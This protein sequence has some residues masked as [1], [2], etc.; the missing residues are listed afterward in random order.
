LK[1]EA[2]SLAKK[3]PLMDGD[4][5]E[6][7]KADIAANGL[8]NPVWIWQVKI[9]DGRNRMRACEELGIEPVFAE[10][11]GTEEEAAAFVDSQNLHRRH[12]STEWRR[13]RAKELRAKGMSL[14]GIGRELGVHNSTVAADLKVKQEPAGNPAPEPPPAAIEPPTPQPAPEPKPPPV[15]QPPPPP[16]VTGRD[17]KTY[18]ASKPV[19]AKSAEEPKPPDDAT[20][21]EKWKQLTD[22]LQSV[23]FTF[24][25]FNTDKGKPCPRKFVETMERTGRA[26]L[27]KA[28]ELRKRHSI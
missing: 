9:L 15:Q 14:R 5:Y 3:Y 11:V 20:D 21:R 17:G 4:E 6:S 23:A 28:L 10:F 13:E 24:E 26:L 27:N 7:L 18:P 8:Q 1:Y 12:L 25:T 22:Q 2:H 19:T 16:R